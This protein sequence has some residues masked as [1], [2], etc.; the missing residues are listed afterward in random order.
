MASGACELHRC[1]RARASL[2]TRSG[3]KM[4]TDRS[5]VNLQDAF[6]SPTH[7]DQ[8]GPS[9]VQYF[10]TLLAKDNIYAYPDDIYERASKLGQAL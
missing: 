2:G 5:V 9:Y 6:L 10:C 3:T 8:L 4:H 7:L 1:A